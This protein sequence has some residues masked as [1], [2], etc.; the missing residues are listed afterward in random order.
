VE[1]S[2]LS[3]QSPGQIHRLQKVDDE[4]AARAANEEVGIESSLPL[5]PIQG[6]WSVPLPPACVQVVVLPRHP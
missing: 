6:A 2:A 1:S 4:W 3:V 5:Y